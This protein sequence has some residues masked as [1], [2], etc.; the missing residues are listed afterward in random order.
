M[1][2]KEKSHCFHCE[3]LPQATYECSREDIH[4]FSAKQLT[5]PSAALGDIGCNFKCF[6]NMRSC[7]PSEKPS[8][9]HMAIAKERETTNFCSNFLNF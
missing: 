1:L 9:L 2:C 3:I 5:D 7:S 6:S 8:S 4:H